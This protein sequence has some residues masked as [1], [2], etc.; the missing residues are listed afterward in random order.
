M[1]MQIQLGAGGPFVNPPPIHAN[2]G[3]SESGSGNAS[4]AYAW[5]LLADHLNIPT[6]AM[7]LMAEATE[8]NGRAWKAARRSVEREMYPVTVSG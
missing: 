2:G 6:D 1:G 8:M 7:G 5:N 3:D 4:S